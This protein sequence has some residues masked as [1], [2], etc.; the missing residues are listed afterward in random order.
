MSTATQTDHN[1]VLAVALYM[2]NILF[3]IF[4]GIFYLALWALVILR[5]K[6]S[7]TITQNHMKQALIAASLTTLIFV[8][9]NI[10]IVYTGG[11]VPLSRSAIMALEM[12]GL[13]I[14]PAFMGL[15]VYALFKAFKSEDIR[16]PIIGRLI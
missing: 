12:Y 5:Y 9:I 8:A 10:F 1:A 2:A 11:Y 15:G 4:G 13:L 3:V 14:L 6:K 7:S 16:Y